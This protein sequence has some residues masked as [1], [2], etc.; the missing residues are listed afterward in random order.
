MTIPSWPAT[1]SYKPE[2][3]GYSAERANP[4][5]AVTQMD[6]GPD[7]MRRRSYTRSYRVP[8]KII[9]EGDTMTQA[10][11]D[12]IE[13]TLADGTLRFRMPVRLPGMTAFTNRICQ[14]EGGVYKFTYT[15]ALDVYALTFNLIVTSAP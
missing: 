15:G 5:A 2:Q 3:D 12:F 10:A 4:A 9:L 11:R 8:Y 6:D 1:V 7:R 14:L 13:T